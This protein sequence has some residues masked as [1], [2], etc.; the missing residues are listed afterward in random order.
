MKPA[1]TDSE[2][3]EVS[4]HCCLKQKQHVICVSVKRRKEDNNL[5]IDST[6]KNL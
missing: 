4:T 3:A 5:T 1:S 2:P 6:N